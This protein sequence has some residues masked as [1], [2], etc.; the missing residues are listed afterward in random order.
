MAKSK[1]KSVDLESDLG[2][3]P[4]A[5]SDTVPEIAPE[6]SPLYGVLKATTHTY[7]A[8]GVSTLLGQ[9]DEVRYRRLAE[10]L[11]EYISVNLLG[12]IKKRGDL[13]KY[14]TNPYVFMASALAMRLTEPD[15][16]SEFVFNNKLYAGL[17]TSFGK[18]I[19]KLFVS[20]YPIGSPETGRWMDAPEK[21]AEAGGLKGLK[22]EEK[23][24]RRV[25]SVWRE[26]DKS[27]VVGNRRY[28]V[29][30][31]SGPNCINDTQV[32]GMT[33]AIA[34]RHGTWLADS[35][36]TY[37]EVTGLDVVIG[38]TYGTDK[39]TNNK[40]NQI[41]AKLL[42]HGFSEEDRRNKPGVLFDESGTVRVYRRI[43]QD[44]WSFIGNPVEPQKAS[45]IFLETLLA[46]VKGLSTGLQAAS[47]RDEINV[48]LAQLSVGF[49]N[50]MLPSEHLPLWASSNLTRNELF[51][52]AT[53]LTAFYDQG[54]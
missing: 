4:D 2:D 8:E 16:L 20:Q 41:L 33:D 53:S 5:V 51:L 32:Q 38:I 30:I 29:S 48:K 18:S 13:S 17:E 35:R 40:E 11:G 9:I 27:C 46:V 47:L 52:L 39:T 43:G 24:R 26:I 49:A 45:F 50:M 15:R 19:E 10:E 22:R 21:V 25:N 37:P 23:A 44:F 7:S 34:S 31:K 12:S 36:T 6:D 42:E 28:L 1:K 3:S 54:I 14:R